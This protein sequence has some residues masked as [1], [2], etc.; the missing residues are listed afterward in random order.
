MAHCYDIEIKGCPA[1]HYL[2]CPAY[3]RG[4]NCWEVENV[5]CCRR[6]DKIRCY[7]CKVYL[8]VLRASSS[9]RV[10]VAT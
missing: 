4:L 3:S 7:S 6:N 10:P 8:K 5:P 2:S 1:S 9:E